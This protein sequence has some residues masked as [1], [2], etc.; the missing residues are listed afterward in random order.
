MD[1]QNEILDFW[2]GDQ[3]EPGYPARDRHKLWFGKNVDTD[4]IISERF[5]IK[6]LNAT[7]SHP[8]E[9]D[10]HVCLALIVLFDQFPRNIYRDTPDAFDYDHH[11]LTVSLQGVESGIDQTLT[12]IER[13]FF[14]LPLE[15]S[16][17]LDVQEKSIAKF[18]ELKE[19]VPIEKKDSFQSY[20]DYAVKHCDIVKRFGRFPHRNRILGRISTPA[21]ADFLQQPGSSF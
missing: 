5:Q 10:A 12:A 11:A 4:R 7:P 3:D 13:V 16:E 9:K 20:L 18:R 17:N 15:H 1:S 8:Q 19:S 2:F 6:L 14:Y 21:E